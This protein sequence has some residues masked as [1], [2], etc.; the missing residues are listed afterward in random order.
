[1]TNSEASFLIDRLVVRAAGG[2]LSVA[3]V[4]VLV[5]LLTD[6]PIPD[7]ELLLIPGVPILFAG[8][9]WAIFL[10]NSRLPWPR[11][12]WLSRWSAQVHAQRS[13]RTVLFGSLSNTLAFGLIVVI[14]LGWLAAMLSF[15]GLLQG[16]PADPMP[17]C[18]WPL[19]SHGFVNCVSQAR[20]QDAGASGERFASGILMFF[21]GMHFGVAYNDLVRRTGRKCPRVGP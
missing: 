17:G 13:L 21:F 11:G 14:V 12:S 7:I 15:P 18:P 5:T 8:Q 1:M 16:N 10:L 3:T 4:I 20:Y 9:L 6:R 2:C 19:M